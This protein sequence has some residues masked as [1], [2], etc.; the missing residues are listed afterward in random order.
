[1]RKTLLVALLLGSAQLAAAK[2]E[3]Y[4]IPLSEDGEVCASILGG[5]IAQLITR[6]RTL[7]FGRDGKLITAPTRIIWSFNDGLAAAREPA[8]NGH[9]GFLNTQGGWQIAP[10][11][12]AVREFADGHA[13]VQ[14]KPDAPW[15]VIDRSGQIKTTLPAEMTPESPFWGGLAMVTI[16]TSQTLWSP[17]QTITLPAGIKA[18]DAPNE[19][20]ILAT[21]GDVLKF[22]YLKLDGQWLIAPAYDSA[23]DFINGF[24]AVKLGEQWQIIDRAGKI[25]RPLPGKQIWG[26]SSKQQWQV[27]LADGSTLLLKA[28][29]SPVQADS[30]QSSTAS[31]ALPAD[32]RAD[33]D[34]Q[35]MMGNTAGLPRALLYPKKDSGKPAGL[36]LADGTVFWPKGALGFGTDGHRQAEM[37]FVL[38]TKS[39]WGAIDAKGNWVIPPR[40]KYLSEFSA[41][42]ASLKQYETEGVAY[43]DGKIVLPTDGSKWSDISSSGIAIFEKDY[44]KGVIDIRSGKVLLP[45]SDEYLSRPIGMVI[46]R[47][48]KGSRMEGLWHLGEARWLLQP[49]CD[50]LKVVNA[51]YWLCAPE[52]RSVKKAF[53]VSLNGERIP[54]DSLKEDYET[55]CFT[56]TS[57]GKHG[58]LT[59]Q[60]LV[61]PPQD[62]NYKLLSGPQEKLWLLNSGGQR[63]A[64]IDPQGKE[65]LS[66]NAEKI[67]RDKDTPDLAVGISNNKT[68][69]FN[70]RQQ[71]QAPQPSQ[72]GERVVHIV[73]KPGMTITYTAAPGMREKTSVT[74]GER[75]LIR[76][77]AWQWAAT[78]TL[79]QSDYSAPGEEKSLWL[80]KENRLVPTPYIHIETAGANDWLRIWDGKQGKYRF[81]DTALKPVLPAYDNATVFDGGLAW[82]LD[83]TQLK[84]LNDKGQTVGQVPTACPGDWTFGNAKPVTCAKQ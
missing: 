47:S 51:G 65:V 25:V 23:R 81:L 43:A 58:L 69:V 50:D 60:G 28:D 15:Q 1:M 63:Y 9:W 56:L 52:R 7:L 35:P 73:A 44:A 84:L 2:T 24:A 62:G 5:G 12:H 19:G 13:L 82:M 76:S 49:E 75:T 36:I 18:W 59:S 38:E 77:G 79:V 39:G 53:L 37:P 26:D 16:P 57:Q 78:D 33:Y 55:G 40:F 3:C 41:G 4:G 68:V 31:A 17:N 70:I 67:Y 29:G 61:W 71:T 83:G 80:I 42:M 64:W 32:L 8:E 11:W 27:E 10:Q 48:P 46:T 66:Y 30:P 6:D 20:L 34:I 22:G 74:L 45:A 14:S 72:E 54:L 21:R